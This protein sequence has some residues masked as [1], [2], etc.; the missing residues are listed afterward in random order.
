MFREIRPASSIVKVEFIDP[1]ILVEVEAEAL[2]G[3]KKEESLP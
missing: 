3:G 2:L 1:K